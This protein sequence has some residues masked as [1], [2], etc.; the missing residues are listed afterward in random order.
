VYGITGESG[1]REF[2]ACWRVQRITG[3]WT[4]RGEH[5]RTSCFVDRGARSGTGRAHTTP[6]A[7]HGQTTEPCRRLDQQISVQ[8]VVD[9]VWPFQSWTGRRRRLMQTG[10]GSSTFSG[11][12]LEHKGQAPASQR[13]PHAVHTKIP[14]PFR[15]PLSQL[16]Q[17][18]AARDHASGS[19]ALCGWK[20]MPPTILRNRRNQRRAACLDAAALILPMFNHNSRWTR[21]VLSASKISLWGSLNAVHVAFSVQ[22]PEGREGRAVTSQH[23]FAVL[24][25]RPTRSFGP[26]KGRPRMQDRAAKGLPSTWRINGRWRTPNFFVVP[27]DI[28]GRNTSAPAFVQLCGSSHM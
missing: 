24:E 23:F 25:L 10:A 17:A 26:L 22:V 21:A 8:R 13:S 9:G 12:A 27:C 3:A 7:R 28:S 5:L 2:P 4:P 1:H 6:Q 18:S 20:I 14:D 16:R 11:N 15:F 19:E